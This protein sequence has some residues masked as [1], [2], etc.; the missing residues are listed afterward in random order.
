MSFHGATGWLYAAYHSSSGSSQ[1]L[2]R[3]HGHIKRAEECSRPN[4]FPTQSASLLM[5][6]MTANKPP[7][8]GKPATSKPGSPAVRTSPS[9]FLVGKRPLH[10]KDKDQ[11][12]ADQNSLLV[13]AVLHRL[14]MPEMSILKS[15]VPKLPSLNTPDHDVASKLVRARGNAS[16]VHYEIS[17]NRNTNQ[18][19]FTLDRDRATKSGRLW[20]RDRLRRRGRRVWRAIPF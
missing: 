14:R 2:A 10:N 3:H 12:M 17:V 16:P 1:Q 13:D 15:S 9:M 6:Q 5:N 11:T 18:I 19:Y 4:E 8:R 20:T 7:A